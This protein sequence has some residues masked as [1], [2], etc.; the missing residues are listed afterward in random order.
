ML[1]AEP[2]REK[3][4]KDDLWD[5]H[6]CDGMVGGTELL[7]PAEATKLVRWNVPGS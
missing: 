5:F 1:L 6:R 3:Y 4:V 7:S 2:K